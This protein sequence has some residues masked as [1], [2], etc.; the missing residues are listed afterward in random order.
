[1]QQKKQ[2]LIQ[3]KLE[4][5][6]DKIR[7]HN[8]RIKEINQYNK[9]NIHF[10]FKENYTTIIPLKLYTCWHTKNLPPLM[11]SN[12]ETLKD[13]NQEF[14][15]HLFDENDCKEFINQHFDKYVLDAYN[16][17]LPCAYKADLWRY[18]VLWIN[19]GIYLDIKY[20]CTNN[21][22]LIALTEKEYF[23][24]DRP[25]KSIYNALIVSLPKNQMLLNAIRQIVKH[26]QTHYYGTNPLMPTG[27]GLLG[28]YMSKE[29]IDNLELYF[30]YTSIDN[31]R[32]DDIVYKDKIILK[33]Y[34]GY[35]NEQKTYQ[36]NLYYS[37]L[38]DMRKIYN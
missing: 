34:S 16:K 11:H 31:I 32:E 15:F 2:K 23:V 26:T 10:E 33:S 5:Y 3:S 7:K 18:C 12:Y 21:F 14:T 8:Q 9:L 27:P 13:S 19:G 30:K 35:R 22:K 38:W 37:V 24:R 6:N 29:D 4:K 28:N 1:L 36:K 20:N 17:L 25:D